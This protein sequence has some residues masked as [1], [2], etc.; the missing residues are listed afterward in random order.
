MTRVP[1]GALVEPGLVGNFQKPLGSGI[2]E[3]GFRW[4]VILASETALMDVLI[5]ILQP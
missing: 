3:A 1:A 4:A 5:L 2:L